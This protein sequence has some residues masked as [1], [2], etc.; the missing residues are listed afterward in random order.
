MNPKITHLLELVE[1]LK[2][3]LKT[4]GPVGSPERTRILLMIMD[5][6]KQ[7]LRLREE[8]LLAATE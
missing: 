5:A 4:S 3:R 7:I 2:E 6:Q 1:A 8:A